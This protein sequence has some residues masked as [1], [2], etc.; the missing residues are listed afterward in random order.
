MSTIKIEFDTEDLKAITAVQELTRSLQVGAV[1]KR[2]EKLE[3]VDAKEVGILSKNPPKA[4]P[5][6]AKPKP[7]PVEEEIEDDEVDTAEPEDEDEDF[8]D[9][10]EAEV[11]ID[12]I[13]A[14]QALKIDK[15]RDALKAQY[16]KLGATGI[17]SLAPENYQ[18]M[19]DFMSKLK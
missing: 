17:S 10:E 1:I 12:D 6:R 5:S 3:V 4:R 11:S 15:H 13:R 14:L 18:A 8:S 19:H 16:K 2:V 9:D 7:E